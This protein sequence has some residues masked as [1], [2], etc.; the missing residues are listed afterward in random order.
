[1]LSYSYYS[2]SLGVEAL[3]RAR[4]S[5]WNLRTEAIISPDDL[6]SAL[7]SF[8]AFSAAECD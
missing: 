6:R 1:M 8:A 4:K 5:G 3:E 2:C 7:H